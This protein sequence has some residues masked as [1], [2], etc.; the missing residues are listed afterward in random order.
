MFV[1]YGIL[2]KCSWNVSKV[3]FI[4]CER[5]LCSPDWFKM[6][7]QHGACLLYT[8][9]Y[10]T[11]KELITTEFIFTQMFGFQLTTMV[12]RMKVV[13]F[14]LTWGERYINHVT[15]ERNRSSRPKI[16]GLLMSIL[17]HNLSR[18]SR[19]GLYA[20]VAG[21]SLSIYLYLLAPKFSTCR[22]DHPVSVQWETTSI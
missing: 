9:V 12:V 4:Y 11:C 18:V 22:T 20:T 5:S 15:R 21:M 19:R 14:T 1:V 17:P 8:S 16:N 6:T 7:V 10:A 3:Y 13:R 2:T